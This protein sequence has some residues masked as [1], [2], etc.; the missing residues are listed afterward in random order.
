[1]PETL[2]WYIAVGKKEEAEEWIKKAAKCN[3]TT[4][5]IDECYTLPENGKQA[6]LTKSKK[7]IIHIF[8]S[9][10]LLPQFLSMCYLW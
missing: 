7:N 5:R 4:V 10:I 2:H 8:K 9:G 3:K 6:P 1:M